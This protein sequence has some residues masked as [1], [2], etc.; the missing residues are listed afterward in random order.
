MNEGDQAVVTE[1]DGL[2]AQVLVLAIATPNVARM[3]ILDGEHCEEIRLEKFFPVS[4]SFLKQ[5][6]TPLCRD[7]PQ[8]PRRSNRGSDLAYC[9]CRMKPLMANLTRQ[10]P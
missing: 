2:A 5:A 8:N 7:Q 3:R 4:C 6:A 10:T 1:F 9:S